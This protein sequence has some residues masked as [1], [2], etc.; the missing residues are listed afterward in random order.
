MNG[1][2][3]TKSK[4]IQNRTLYSLEKLIE[5]KL[6]LDLPPL[7]DSKPLYSLEKLIEW[8]QYAVPN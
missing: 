7:I 6:G 4:A 5:W 1:N 3:R 2:I 8:K